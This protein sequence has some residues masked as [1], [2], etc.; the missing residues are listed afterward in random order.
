MLKQERYD[1]I[2]SQLNQNN[3]VTAATLSEAL[4]LS[5]ATVRR[6]LT[7]LDALGKLQKVHGGALPP[8]APVFSFRQRERIH[9]QAK[10]K[11]IQKVLPLLAGVRTIIIDAGT[12]NLA[13]VKQLPP[14]WQATCFTNSPPIAQQLVQHPDVEVMLTGGTYAEQQEALV[15]PWVLQTLRQVYADVCL[16]GVCSLH[17]TYGLTTESSEIAASKQTMIQ[18]ARRTI[19]LANAEKIDTVDTYLVDTID[20]VD[21]IVTDL[22]SDDPRWEKYRADLLEIV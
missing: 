2:L 11:I 7:E 9:T 16:L 10:E 17:H 1:F 18:Q 13:L 5:E 6:D 15:G 12:T 14:D 3:K 8:V 21:T 22:P 19:A 4:N 20:R